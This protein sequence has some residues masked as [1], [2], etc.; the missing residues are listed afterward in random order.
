MTASFARAAVA[1]EGLGNAAFPPHHPRSPG[2]LPAVHDGGIMP[3]IAEKAKLPGA[4]RSSSSPFGD[5]KISEE[6]EERLQ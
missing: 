3:A 6:S 4:T 2:E 5:F 1:H